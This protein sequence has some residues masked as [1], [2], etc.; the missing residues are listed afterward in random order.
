MMLA[1]AA[2]AT[3]RLLLAV[4]TGIRL[5]RCSDRGKTSVNPEAT[6]KYRNLGNAP[7]LVLAIV[8]S[9]MSCHKAASPSS[10]PAMTGQSAATDPDVPSMPVYAELIRIDVGTGAITRRVVVRGT[11]LQRLCNE[12]HWPWDNTKRSRIGGGWDAGAAIIFH[13]EGGQ[14]HT[15]EIAESFVAASDRNGGDVLL[16]SGFRRYFE[17]LL[18]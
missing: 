10:T 17:E 18:K 11:E 9:T 5:Q 6:M 8:C 2:C 1:A 14:I 7:V 3:R 4:V 12:L 16:T 13:D 15:V